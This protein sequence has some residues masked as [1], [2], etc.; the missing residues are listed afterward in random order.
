MEKRFEKDILI[1]CA[2]AGHKNFN[3]ALA[4][5]LQRQPTPQ[6]VRRTWQREKDTERERGKKK[7]SERES[8]EKGRENLFKWVRVRSRKKVFFSQ[9]YL[10]QH[11]GTYRLFS[12]YKWTTYISPYIGMLFLLL[13]YFCVSCTFLLL[14]ISKVSLWLKLVA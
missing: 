10:G 13:S 3:N 12:Q 7:M 14:F 5:D 6:Y 4:R 8:K 11:R 2:C 1:V 9:E